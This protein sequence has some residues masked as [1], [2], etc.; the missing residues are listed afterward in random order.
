MA[1][2]ALDRKGRVLGRRLMATPPNTAAYRRLLKRCE[3][4]AAAVIRYALRFED[5]RRRATARERKEEL[6]VCTR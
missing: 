3:R 5:A 6:T 4:R 2:G 1:V